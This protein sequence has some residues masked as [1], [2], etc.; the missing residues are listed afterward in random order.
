MTTVGKRFRF[1]KVI[2][3]GGFGKVYLA[4]M[5]STDGFSRIVAV[6]VL[7]SKWSSHDEVVMRTRDEARLLGLIRHQHIV[8]VE[9]LTSI[10]GLCAIVMEYLE[11]LDMKCVAKYQNALGLA[12]PNATIFE[13]MVAVTSALDAAY[14]GKPL[15]SDASLQVIHRDIKPSNIFLTTNGNVK[16]LDFGTARANFAEREAKTMELSF[17]S[18]GYMAPERLLGEPDTP[19]ADIFSLGVTLYELLAREPFGRIVPRAAKL[20][21]KVA[22]RVASLQLSGDDAWVISVK[23]TLIEMLSAEP[24]ERPTADALIDMFD[25]LARRADG[26]GLR[27]FCRSTVVEAKR[28]EPVQSAE[29]D[30]LFGRTVPVDVSGV[31]ANAETEADETAPTAP[32]K[33]TTSPTARQDALS[34][35]DAFEGTK[36]RSMS[37]PIAA[38]VAALLLFGGGYALLGDDVAPEE[39]KQIAKEE[40]KP[41]EKLKEETSKPSTTGLEIK[42]TSMGEASNRATEVL[43]ALPKDEKATV[44][45]RN[46]SNN[47]NARWEASGEVSLG[48]LSAGTYVTN[49]TV[50]GKGKIRKKTFE[51]QAGKQCAFTFDFSARRWDG[52]CE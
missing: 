20:T 4:E 1:M 24:S 14:N 30:P 42:S 9:D 16:V 34:T 18:Q 28:V 22:E 3:E 41:V 27:K 33:E 38:G 46:R 39:T 51:V 2:A 49:L 12:I 10:N 48:D 7:H 40:I 44:F 8:K 31:F 35:D 37:L 43:L 36:S 17:G 45:I 5:M 11:G 15:Q 50:E 23:E 25:D 47:F 52:N 6:K 21:A 19:A 13:S 26:D 29:D 32:L